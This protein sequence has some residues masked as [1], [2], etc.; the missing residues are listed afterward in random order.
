[1]T[2]CRRLRHRRGS[3]LR[4]RPFRVPSSMWGW[5]GGETGGRDTCEDEW[6]TET[7]TQT[8]SDF[9][10]ARVAEDEA[11]TFELVPYKCD[12]GCCAPAGWV[13]HRCLIC[14]TPAEYGGAVAAITDIAREHEERVHRRSRT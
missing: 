11:P 8:L 6:G 10:L 14:G 7:S 9:L 5:C 1:M 4:F 12:P 2:R 13:G 3:G